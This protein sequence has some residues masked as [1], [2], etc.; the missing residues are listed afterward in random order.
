MHGSEHL[1]M[2]GSERVC[3]HGSERV[4]MHGMHLGVGGGGGLFSIA[5]EGYMVR[6]DVSVIWR[7]GLLI[8]ALDC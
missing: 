1:C 3:M 6:T 8:A 2:H 7:P 4:C 5:F